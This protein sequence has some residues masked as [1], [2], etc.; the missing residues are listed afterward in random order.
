MIHEQQDL[1]FKTAQT[2][3]LQREHERLKERFQELE[4]RYRALY[5]RSIYCIYLHD[6]EGRF[7]DAN[8]AT[9]RALG[10]TKEEF[11]SLNLRSVLG[12]TQA[13]EAYSRIPEI[14]KEGASREV[15]EYSLKTKDGNTLWI[16]V[17]VSLIYQEGRPYAI[18]GVAKDI[19]LSKQAELA[20]RESEKNTGPCL[21]NLQ[22]RS[23]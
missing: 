1:R 6:L 17:D 16:E 12:E 8:A 10:Y 14:L 19:T 23:T 21:N 7:L 22:M 2:E 4:A 18:Q 3:T 20:L 15:K 5:D 11:L 13:Q 9:L